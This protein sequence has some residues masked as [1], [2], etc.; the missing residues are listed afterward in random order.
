LRAHG[1]TLVGIKDRR[2]VL[3]PAGVADAAV[4]LAQS[5]MHAARLD[6]IDN[7][8]ADPELSAERLPLRVRDK[9]FRG[10]PGLDFALRLDAAFFASLA[11]SARVAVGLYA[12]STAPVPHEQADL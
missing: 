8:L 10:A 2:A 11:T 5:G 12:L 3:P 6:P 1:V 9:R 7:G 4:I